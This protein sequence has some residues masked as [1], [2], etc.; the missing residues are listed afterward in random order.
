MNGAF[1]AELHLPRGAAD[2]DRTVA[3]LM[4]MEVR[5]TTA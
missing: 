4:A 1:A 2:L 3:R 5:A